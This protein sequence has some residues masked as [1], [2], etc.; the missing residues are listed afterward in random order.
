MPSVQ[1]ALRLLEKGK[2]V[3]AKDV[4]SFIITGENGGSAEKAA[5]NA[6]TLDEVVKTGSGLKPGKFYSR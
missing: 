2:H 3:R 5:Q 1:V 4:M 6:C